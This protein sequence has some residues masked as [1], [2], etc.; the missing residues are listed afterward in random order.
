MYLSSKYDISI[1]Y[2]SQ[3][4]NGEFKGEIKQ[5]IDELISQGKTIT[6]KAVIDTA[7]EIQRR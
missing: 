6:K 3:K 7:F 4:I 2:N 5:A 1:T